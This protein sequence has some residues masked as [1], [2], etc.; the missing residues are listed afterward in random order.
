[1][2][3]PLNFR[4]FI[5]PSMVPSVLPTIA[6]S[7]ET[8]ITIPPSPYRPEVFQR[9]RGLITKFNLPDMRHILA[10]MTRRH[11]GRMG[12]TTAP[13]RERERR[14]EKRRKDIEDEVIILFFFSL[15]L[16]FFL[17]PPPSLSLLKNRNLI[18]M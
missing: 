10:L 13:F 11:V 5:W 3:L 6:V 8:Y 16:F 15:F 18:E 17:P 14:E 9:Y 4:H 2:D 1:M 7:G 12:L